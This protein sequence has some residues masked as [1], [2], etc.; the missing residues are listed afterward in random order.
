VTNPDKRVTIIR[1]Y[2]KMHFAATPILD[3]A[4]EVW[5]LDRVHLLR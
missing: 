5:R 3:F 1:D 4:L 2:A